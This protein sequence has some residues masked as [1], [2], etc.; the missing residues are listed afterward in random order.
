[1]KA[2]ESLELWFLT[3]SQEL[4]GQQVL[5]KVADDAGQIAR[6]LDASAAIPV[7]IID[8]P[9]VTSSDDV[10]RACIEANASDSCIGVIAWMHTFSPARMWISGLQTLQKP[11]LHLHTQFNR[12]L[13]WSDIDMDF[14]NL[15][16][17]A[18]GDRE[19]GFIGSRMRSLQ[20]GRGR[21]LAATRTWRNGSLPGAVPPRPGARRT[22]CVWP[23]SATTCDRWP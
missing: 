2:M 7:R 16:Q 10:R 20:E 12:D 1:M 13:P 19:F 5:D 15:N 9:V 11:L 17:A 6:T 22:T 4:Y 21:A 8:R 18:H 3:G 23:G 14:M